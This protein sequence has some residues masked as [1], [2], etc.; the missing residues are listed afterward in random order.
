M[1]FFY[2]CYAHVTPMLRQTT[3][4]ILTHVKYLGVSTPFVKTVNSLSLQT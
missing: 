3:H 4:V 1:C 2:A